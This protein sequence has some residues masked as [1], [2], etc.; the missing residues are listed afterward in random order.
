ML[1]E[2]AA[3][4]L[5]Q[6]GKSEAAARRYEECEQALAAAISVSQ[7]SGSTPEH[8]DL[9]EHRLVLL[10]RIQSLRGSPAKEV[11]SAQPKPQGW[12]RPGS[13]R[14]RRSIKEK[15]ASRIAKAQR[16]KAERDSLT[17]TDTYVGM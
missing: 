10:E 3:I 1:A 8:G 5:E 12:W 13:G 16:N 14:L 7:R 2:E 15:I 4:D 11:P 9:V 17:L 6:A